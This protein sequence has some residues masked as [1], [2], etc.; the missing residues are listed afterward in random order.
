MNKSILFKKG[1]CQYTPIIYHFSSVYCNLLGLS[2]YFNCFAIFVSTYDEIG[3]VYDLK[4]LTKKQ[5]AIYL[6]FQVLKD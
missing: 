6:I 1:T 4:S 3:V 2:D 5:E